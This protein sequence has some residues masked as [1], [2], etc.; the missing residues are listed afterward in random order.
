MLG[1]LLAAILGG[2]IISGWEDPTWIFLDILALRYLTLQLHSRFVIISKIKQ[3]GIEQ[4]KRTPWRDHPPIDLNKGISQVHRFP[5]VDEELEII[6]LS[7]GE[8]QRMNSRT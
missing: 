1:G 6:A 4:S 2:L 3:K 5:V 7:E 8:V